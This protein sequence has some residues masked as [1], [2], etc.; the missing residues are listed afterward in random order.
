MP[1]KF[2]FTD[3]ETFLRR[4]P[5][6]E[7]R[8]SMGVENGP[9]V[10]KVPIDIDHPLAWR[11]VQELGHILN[12]LSVN[13][14]LPTVFMPVSPPVYLN[15]GPR[16]HLSW[17]IESKSTD[18]EPRMCAEWLEGRLHSRRRHFRARAALRSESHEARSAAI[19]S[20]RIF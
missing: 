10:G 18:F 4:V 6:I 13:E 5:A 15:G 7:E 12:Y 20:R 3:L 16:D 9:L 8:I 2:D 14:R 19:A 1:D 17:V 11:V